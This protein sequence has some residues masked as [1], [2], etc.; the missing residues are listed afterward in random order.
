MSWVPF[1]YKTC[2]SNYNHGMAL[3][4]Y[5]F[6][7]LVQIYIILSVFWLNYVIIVLAFCTHLYN[8]YFV[9]IKDKTTVKNLK[10]SL[11]INECLFFFQLPSKS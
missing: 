8:K 1:V 3:T 5:L 2:Y 9:L 6:Y 4:Y 11:K 7:L 10:K